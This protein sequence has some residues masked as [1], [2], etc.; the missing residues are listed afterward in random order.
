MILKAD[1]IVVGG[2]PVGLTLACELRLAGLD[3]LVL[4]RRAERVSNSRGMGMHLSLIH[5]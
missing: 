3:V 1:V 2:G 4:E 5:I